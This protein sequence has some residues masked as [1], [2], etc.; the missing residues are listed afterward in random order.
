ML[1]KNSM[2]TAVN[3]AYAKQAQ[4]AAGKKNT[5]AQEE[6]AQK[7]EKA[8]ELT[9]SAKLRQVAEENILSAQSS[10]LDVSKAEEMIRQ[11][12]QNILNQADDALKVQSGQTAAAAIELLK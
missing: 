2:E 8:A 6:K 4:P 10:V 9:L 12:N 1:V 3:A 11:A 5:L 7:P